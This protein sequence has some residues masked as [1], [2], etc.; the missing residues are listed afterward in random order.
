MRERGYV[1]DRIE[2][3]WNAAWQKAREGLSQGND[4]SFWDKR[5]P[6]FA[7]HV[8]ETDYERRFLDLMQPDPS[9]SVLD[10]GCGA[11]TLAIPLARRVASVTAVDFSRV[12]LD[13]LRQSCR[14]EG[15]S[16]VTSIH[17]S[18]DDDWESLGVGSHDAVIA[19][20]S[21]VAFDLREAITKLDRAARRGV[22]ISSLVGDGPQDRR[23]YEAVGRTLVSGPDYIY[24]Y[25]LLYQMGI[26][27]TINFITHREWKVYG[28]LD[29]ALEGNC[30]MLKDV[31]Q[32]ELELL[33][34][35][36]S[37]SL[38]PHEGGWRMPE[39]RVVR[40]ALISWEKDAE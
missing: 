40:W 33:R 15:I 11:G 22:Y 24:L 10:F 13:L 2:I 6:A 9:W 19:S 39:P 21:L 12:M 3:D 26:R 8:K 30:W 31:T 28:N 18:W 7:R 5:A 38:V 37:A 16:N 29:A 4:S 1:M 23:I 27:A 36:L 17:G 20:R 25:N 32:E 14:E 34:G 35:Y